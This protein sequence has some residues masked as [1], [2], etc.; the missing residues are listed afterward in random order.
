MKV[1]STYAQQ[2]SSE[3]ETAYVAAEDE[4]ESAGKRLEAA[5]REA[6]ETRLK[7]AAA[8]KKRDAARHAASTLKHEEAQAQK[9]VETAER[10]YHSAEAHWANFA[11]TQK[12]P[13]APTHEESLAESIRKM[14][15]LRREDT[16]ARAGKASAQPTGSTNG[17]SQQRR[18]EA[19]AAQAEEKERNRCKIRDQVKYNP[20]R[21][22]LD[23][24]LERHICVCQEFDSITF[25][26]SQP[27]TFESVPWPV[28]LPPLGFTVD[29]ISWG[30]VTSFFEAMK[31]KMTEEDYRSLLQKSQRRFHPD[32][33]SSRRLIKTIKDPVIATQIENAGKVVSQAVNALRE[34][35][36]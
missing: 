21:W 14:E 8:L 7:A 13:R 30:E 25:D 27:L 28:R 24:A 29:K 22:N 18:T 20:W 11:S 3:A 31:L 5:L 1:K 9:K 19:E 4:F 36:R 32:K 10:V 16:E 6:E 34:N 26:G 23:K 15:Q 2:T 35:L 33:W 17:E 12:D